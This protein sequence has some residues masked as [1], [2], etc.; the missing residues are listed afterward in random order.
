MLIHSFA[1]KFQ[2]LITVIV[3]GIF[4]YFLHVRQLTIAGSLGRGEA[5]GEGAFSNHH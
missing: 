5:G 1:K 2:M 4:T 3:L